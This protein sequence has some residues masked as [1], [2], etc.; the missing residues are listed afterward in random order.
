MSGQESDRS[1]VV[2]DGRAVR[3]AKGST[4][5]QSGESTRAEGRK[6]PRKSVSSSLTALRDKA[7]RDPSHRFRSLYSMIDLPML[8]E[9]FGMLRRDAACGVDKVSVADFERD[10][11]G[12]LAGLLERLKAKRYRAKL[13]RRKYIPK[14]GGKFRPLGIP[15]VEDKIPGESW[16]PS[17]K[18]TSWTRAGGT[19][20]PRRRNS[21]RRC[22]ASF[23]ATTT[24]T[25]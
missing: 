8:H 24:T 12:N 18:R 14:S 3:M 9:S 20:A 13:V 21:A 25:A 1:I 4:G 7:L 19:A 16:N 23:L 5:R 10:L 11:E 15:A 17:T 22:L 6:A 2:R